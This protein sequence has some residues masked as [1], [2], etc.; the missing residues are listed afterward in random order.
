MVIYLQVEW[1]PESPER[2]D[3]ISELLKSVESL[4]L[5][6]GKSQGPSLSFFLFF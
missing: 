1:K 5:E 3:E 6:G 4:K 2:F